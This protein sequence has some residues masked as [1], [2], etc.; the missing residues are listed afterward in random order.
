MKNV[1][2]V[3]IILTCIS[4]SFKKDIALV[5]DYSNKSKESLE[6]LL[7]AID[8][9]ESE[10]YETQIEKL[11]PEYSRYKNIKHIKSL[12][13]HY[14]IKGRKE[15]IISLKEYIESLDYIINNKE[16]AFTKKMKSL[17]SKLKKIDAKKL[18][19][20]FDKTITFVD[21]Q[22]EKGK[23]NAIFKA[24][25]LIAKDSESA[26]NIINQ[27][28]PAVNALIKIGNLIGEKQKSNSLHKL[29]KEMNK[30]VIAICNLIINDIGS[31]ADDNNKSTQSLREIYWSASGE[32]IRDVNNFVIN[33]KN[34]TFF[35]K[36]SQIKL[37]SNTIYN[38]NKIDLIFKKLQHSVILIKNAHIKLNNQLN[39]GKKEGDLKEMIIELG[40]YKSKINKI[41]ASLRQ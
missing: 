31:K 35:E 25:K 21:K 10:Y 1:I 30:S 36:S 17:G 6:S 23:A 11:V 34:I 16:I 3:I 28:N 39:Y 15:I 37:L 5:R 4:C 2:F 40:D 27:L 13:D 12:L 20:V 41:E 8:I 33:N 18:N 29:I 19:K 14:E 26:V 32:V 22:Q 24:V 9:A 7:N 38:R